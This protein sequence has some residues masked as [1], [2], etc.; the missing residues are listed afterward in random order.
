MG[1][2]NEA[3]NSSPISLWIG[4]FSPVCALTENATV[5][6]MPCQSASRI[7]GHS[8]T[9]AAELAR[10]PH[11]VIFLRR[12]KHSCV[13]GKGLYIDYLLVI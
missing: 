12:M 6:C 8:F 3:N 9:P 4:A 2:L 1:V 10:W 13:T 11:G 7:T 5:N